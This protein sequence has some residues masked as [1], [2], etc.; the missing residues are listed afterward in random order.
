GTTGSPK[1]SQGHDIDFLLEQFD[2]IGNELTY[3]NYPLAWS[4]A[5][6]TPFRYWK[7]DANSEG[8]THNPLIVHYPAGIKEKG[9]V[10]AQYGH[11]ID[12]LPT[13]VEAT[14]VHIPEI[15]NGYQQ[16]PIHGES[17]AHSFNDANA[18]AKRTTQYYEIHGGRAI[19]H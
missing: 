4:Q 17:L 8:A 7:S 15:I 12:L 16:L 6:N 1:G 11:V 18:P 3:P 14:G 9:G 5:T 13:A 2:N 10:R 19:Y